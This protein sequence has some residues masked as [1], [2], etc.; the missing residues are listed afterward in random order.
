MRGEP[1]RVILK[2]V[3]ASDP[4]PALKVVRASDPRPC[5]HPLRR[6]LNTRSIPLDMQ[7]A[8]KTKGGMAGK[9]ELVRDSSSWIAVVCDHRTHYPTKCLE[10]DPKFAL[11]SSLF[12]KANSNFERSVVFNLWLTTRT[13]ELI[14]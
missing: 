14:V 2:M 6:L 12:D 11:A 1:K 4:R 7:V 3:R 10:E 8:F 9:D 5:H 13:D